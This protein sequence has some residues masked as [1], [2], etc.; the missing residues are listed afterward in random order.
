[1]EVLLKKNVDNLGEK[2]ELVTVK[3]GYGRNY[4]I[5][6]GYAILAT[7]SIKKMHAETLRQRAHKAEKIKA[8]AQ[9]T[10][11][12]LAKATIEVGAKVG[13]NG[14]IFGSVSNV[15][16]GEALTAAGFD[17]ERKKIKLI[18]DAIKTVGSY[19]AEVTIHKEIKITIDFKVVEA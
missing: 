1:M 9:A 13:E 11:D 19:Q 12:K 2:D 6:Q 7:E 15:Q 17:I 14:K 16:V 4:L 3:P 18:G 8:E 10:A 5:P